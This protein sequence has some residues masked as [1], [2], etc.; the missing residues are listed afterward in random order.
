[1]YF[2]LEED[3]KVKNFKWSQPLR[4]TPVTPALKAEEGGLSI[5]GE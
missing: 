5:Q 2:I 1:M 3:F 4:C